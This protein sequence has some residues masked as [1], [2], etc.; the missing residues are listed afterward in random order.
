MKRYQFLVQERADL[1]KEAKAIMAG[2]DG[3]ELTEDERQRDDA[4]HSRIQ[5]VDDEIAREERLREA[6]RRAPAV[7]KSQPAPAADNAL[8]QYEQVQATTLAE[9]RR[10]YWNS[11][12]AARDEARLIKAYLAGKP[13]SETDLRQHLMAA[14][15]DTDMNIGTAADGGNA[16]PVGHYRGIIAKADESRLDTRLGVMPI[17][18]VGTTVNVPNESGSANVFV[19]TNEASDFDRDAPALGKVE[20]TLVKLTKNVELSVELL[21]DEDSRLMAFLDIYVGRA[22]ARTY[23]S[24]LVTA[25]AAG[26]Q[27]YALS[28]ASAIA[29][30]DI[31]GVVYGLKEPYAEGAAWVM[32]RSTEGAIRALSGNNWQFMNTPAGGVET[33]LWGFPTYNSEFVAAPGANNK[34]MYFG[35]F[36]YVGRRDGGLTFLRNP[37]LLGS[38]GQVV[39]HYYTRTVFK[40]LQAEA[41]LAATHPSA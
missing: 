24:L 20:M 6:E 41:I 9:R 35:D 13:G 12:P 29:A 39:L 3:R 5:V 30:A 32:K 10:Q 1:V 21:E 40:V 18:G 31:P 38:K 27:A 17:P 36:S 8:F 33:R 34:S 7:I 2:A 15:N 28:S 37:Y 4:I 25:L 22:L 19:A 16:V 23:N 14:S 11:S 26:A